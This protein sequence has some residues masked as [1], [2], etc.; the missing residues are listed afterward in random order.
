M[1][2]GIGY[3]AATVHRAS[4]DLSRKRNGNFLFLLL[5]NTRLKKRISSYELS[6]GVSKSISARWALAT[7][8][9]RAAIEQALS[10]S[11][12]PIVNHIQHNA[13]YA[14]GPRWQGRHC[15]AV[16]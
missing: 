9:D 3:A 12:A 2:K 6:V 7:P 8:V 1:A 13:A 10:K 4:P 15:G 11:L 16:A 14:V 5:Q